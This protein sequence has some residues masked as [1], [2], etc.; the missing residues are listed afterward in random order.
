MNCIEYIIHNGAN[1]FSP[2]FIKDKYG[3]SERKINKMVAWIKTSHH[4]PEIDL[5][6]NDYSIF[7]FVQSKF[8]ALN[9]F[10]S[11]EGISI[12]ETCIP[13]YMAYHKINQI[14]WE[15][16]NL[17]IDNEDIYQLRS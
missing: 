13:L 10:F 9:R 2:S 3:I 14:E 11:R 6:S 16:E 5:L 7:V 8:P 15:V 12:I 17:S 4:G 1:Y